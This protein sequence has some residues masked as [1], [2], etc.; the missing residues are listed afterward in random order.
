MPGTWK[1]ARE[2]KA[3]YMLLLLPA[4]SLFV[5]NYIPM[6]G[7]LIAFK[8][9][10]Y[11]KGIWGSEWNQFAHF[12]ALYN[13]LVFRRAFWN[14]LRINVLSIL[15]LTP[16]PIL[17]ALLLNEIRHTVF[18]R[19][20]QSISYLPHFMSWVVIGGF[21]YQLLS[22]EI[23]F[24]NAVL[25]L[26]GIEPILFMTKVNLFIPILFSASIW[27]S[28]GWGS[29]IY[30]AAI[31][32]ID[33]GLYESAELD[34][35]TRLQKAIYITIPSIVPTIVILFILGLGSILSAGFEPIFNLYNAMV[36]PVADVIDTYVYRKGLLES[37]FSY[38]AAVGVFQ[39]LIG[40][41][42]VYVS[43]RIIKKISDYGIW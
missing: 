35:A 16:M 12:K 43:N 7:V 6:Y 23:G 29:I 22:P 21:V 26:F 36:M 5:F 19:V 9:Y 17:F 41:M 13:D 40:L 3:L 39:S 27:A 30:L 18:K 20:V 34:G 28:V 37:K 1:K 10:V 33:P 32:A 38:A 11:V 15:I 31:S 42:L 25:A 2:M 14:T 4:A 24:V 8:D